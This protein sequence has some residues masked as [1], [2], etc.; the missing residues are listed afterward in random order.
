MRTL[1][2]PAV[3]LALWVLVALPA[4]N[5]ESD[6]VPVC[7]GH[8][9]GEQWTAADGCN[10]CTCE[11]QGASC[12]EMACPEETCEDG[13]LPGDSWDAE[14]GCNTCTCMGDLS[15]ACTLMACVNSCDDGH[16]VG[17]TWDAEDGCNSCTCMA[18]LN[19][20]CTAMACVEACD[21]GHLVGESWDAEDGCNTCTCTEDFAIA[22]TEMACIEACADGHLVGESWDADD[23]CNTCTCTEDLQIAC[24]KIACPP[25][26]CE[27]LEKEY[28][29]LVSAH[30]ACQADH[31]CQFLFG[32][33][34]VGV[35]GCYEIV[36]LTL[37]QEDLEAIA[38]LFNDGECTQWVC[39]CAPPPQSV[40]CEAGVCTA[41]WAF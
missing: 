38:D 23:G 39:D 27:D 36:N 11:E 5:L 37:Q 28:A 22:C 26:S 35:G 41:E 12:T 8:A 34:G 14:D 7:E 30:Q 20:A 40:F 1:R 4:C 3:A 16:L 2:I 24:T 33:C 18:D 25:K 17:E 15:V 10:T 29:A 31:E 6:P 9:L 21:D 32:F 19:I 13:H